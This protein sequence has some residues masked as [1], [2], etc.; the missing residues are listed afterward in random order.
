[1]I[2]KAVGAALPSI[3]VTGNPSSWTK[4]AT[5]TWKAAPGSGTGA[6]AL[7]FVYTPKGIVTENMTG[8]SCTV[9]KNGVYEFMVTDKFGNSAATEVLVTRIDNEA[10][11]LEALTAAGSKPGTI[12]LTGVTDDHT[13][14]YD[15]KGSITGY[16]GSGIKTREY[17]MHGD[18]RWTTF[19]G[20]S[21]TVTKNG[22]YVVRL[23]DNAGNVSEEY[24][25]EITGMDTT[26][27]TVSCTVNGTLNGT[28]GW[29]PYSDVSVKLTFTDK[30][31]AEGGTPS[32]VQSAAYQWVTDT[33]Q[34]PVT[35]MVNLDAAAVAAGEYTISLSD[36]Y[37]TCYLYYKVTD[38]KGNVRDGFSKQIK[39]DDVHRLGF[40]GPDK[41]QPLSAGLPMN[42]SLTRWG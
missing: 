11:K 20:D 37:G 28:S 23:T 7:A 21:L 42:V 18:S 10:P 9:T 6:G 16:S 35:G 39:K 2:K 24:R 25:V 8:G 12:R 38:Q 3:T 15:K 5:L 22:S 13:A 17:R 29:Y 41:A 14:V 34:K 40:T 4:S 1:M 33:S 27:P 31:G 30:V 19:T 36:Y 26:A 32:G